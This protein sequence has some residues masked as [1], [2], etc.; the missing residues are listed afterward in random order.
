M[1]RKQGMKLK[2][3][4][5]ARN[6]WSVGNL[7][8]CQRSY[9]AGDIAQCPIGRINRIKGKIIMSIGTSHVFSVLSPKSAAMEGQRLVRLI[10]KKSKSQSDNLT[11]SM[12]VSVP[13][14]SVE[15][16]AENIDALTPF[17]V[18]MVQDTQDKLIREYR[19]NTGAASVPESEFAMDKV[20]EFLQA[21]ATGER[22]T[23]AM[24]K[25]WFM[26]NYSEPVA[27]WIKQRPGMDGLI[28]SE[29]AQKVRAVC[30]VFESFADPRAKLAPK[31]C[32]MVVE[33]ASSVAEPDY[34]MGTI[35]QKAQAMIE[36]IE[37]EKNA[38]DGLF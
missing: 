20:I 10:V 4:S 15:T 33:I 25:E 13:I 11:E 3:R 32:A 1:D 30:G 8:N 16:V 12:C 36:K 38:L 34:R 18:G 2:A 22:L 5:V 24:I 23:S 7:V 26:E 35:A 19:V 31:V 17:V 37:S 21:N 28:D 9:I 14:T 29:I 6:V 27:E